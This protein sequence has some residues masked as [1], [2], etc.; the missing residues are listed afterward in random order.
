MNKYYLKDWNLKDL[1][2]KGISVKASVPGDI[3]ADLFAG[4]MIEDPYY[5]MN[6]KECTW[7]GET[8]F[9]YESSFVVPDSIWKEDEI[10]LCFDGVDLY[11][12]I[13][14]N[15]ELLGKT[16]DMFLAYQYEVKSQLKKGE[17]ILSVQMHSTLKAMEHIDCEDYNGIFNRPRIMMR[18]VQC[19][20]GWDW[21]PK[22]SG[23][24][25]WKDVYLMGKNRHCLEDVY[26]ETH[27]D[28]WVTFFTELSY[29]VQPHRDL[30][31]Y[32]I[33]GSAEEYQD[34]TLIFS[35]ENEPF[36]ECYQTVSKKVRGAKSFTNIKVEKPKLWW[37]NGYG[38]QPLYQYK[39]ELYRNGL[40][41]SEQHGRLA[42]REVKLLEEPKSED[43]L[44]FEFEINGERIFLKGS[45]WVPAEI[46]TGTIT[47]DRYQTLLTYAKDANYN[48]MRVWGGGLYENEEFYEL[49]DEYGITVIQDFMLSC[50][51]VPGNTVAWTE[52]MKQ[53]AIYQVK[54]LRNHPSIIY[55]NG[56]NEKI[57]AICL[58][59]GC[60][61]WFNETVLSG[62]VAYYTSG[63][64]YRRQC[65]ISYTDMDN[66]GT[67]GDVH[68]ASIGSCLTEDL[69]GYRARIA[70]HTYNF[71][72]EIAVMGPNSL[73]TNEKIYP[74][75]QLWPQ[76]PVWREHI[77]EN[78]YDCMDWDFLDM[79]H[80]YIE[81]FYG[82]AENLNE[83]TFKGMLYHAEALK[84]ESE[85]S[86]FRKGSTMGCANWMY[87]DIWPSG[88]WSVV[89]YYGE[90]K[91]AYYQQRKSYAP[92]LVSFSQN[93]QGE[94][95][96]FIA[97][98]TPKQ[99]KMILECGRKK[100]DGTVLWK[101]EL[102]VDISENGYFSKPIFEGVSEK[103]TYFYV[104]GQDSEG[105]NYHNLYSQL[106]WNGCTF[107]SDYSVETEA[108]SE[109]KLKVKIQA[110]KFA[111]SVFLSFPDNFE[112][113]YSD[114]Y[115]D[116]E[117][118]ETCVVYIT[119]SHQI[120]VEKLIVTDMGALK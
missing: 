60:D 12:D 106:F 78:P 76:G 72:T 22:M 91:Q 44:G 80:I 62:I 112:Y 54:R 114:N 33:E 14:L 13:F 34:D 90:P 61:N 11:A 63:V 79:Q 111:K 50:A 93:E 52:L 43:V 86:R 81:K 97:N 96:L 108:V 119:S 84:A 55:W 25:I 66:D 65:P 10:Y 99:K 101:E 98:D 87:N 53:E 107:E 64:P 58:Q 7:I 118:G 116:I 24:G 41:V 115:L 57:G 4:K 105:E 38:E 16:E 28:G 42:F 102:H 113:N 2:E 45:N 83:F 56:G 117:A 19:H 18:K 71:L 1:N 17:N 103:D 29:N 77:M 92:V 26:F 70:E 74:K 20:F 48:M 109:T 68:T 3:T 30:D 27:N 31:G 47:N 94:T 73:E 32:V 40:L 104:K 15:G 82:K 39:V 35:I 9:L 59:Y 120:P 23:Y 6:Y 21:A 69:E 46:F 49:C 95:C 89:D 67:S 75:D 85:Y 100:L 8:D 110:L 5:A 37:P 36:S 88:T 51:D